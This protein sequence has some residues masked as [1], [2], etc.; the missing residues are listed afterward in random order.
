MA[1]GPDLPRAPRCAQ[2]GAAATNL[3]KTTGGVSFPACDVHG[4]WGRQPIPVL[5]AAPL[6]APSPSVQAEGSRP[7]LIDALATAITMLAASTRLLGGA[8]ANV[9]YSPDNFAA[10]LSLGAVL[11]YE[12]SDGTRIYELSTD[13]VLLFMAVA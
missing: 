13:G 8:T 1:I 7:P 9:R 4:A 11:H 3:S 2:C 12:V 6:A 10:F 5:D